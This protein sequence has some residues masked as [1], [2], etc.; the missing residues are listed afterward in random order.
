MDIG[1]AYVEVYVI[2]GSRVQVSMYVPPM[3]LRDGHCASP[4]A[5]FYVRSSNG[6]T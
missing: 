3:V 1:S 2:Y 6:V 4:S 5:G